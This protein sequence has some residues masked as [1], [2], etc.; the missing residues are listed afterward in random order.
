MLVARYPGTLLVKRSADGTLTVS[1]TLPFERYLDGIAE[2]PPSW[3]RAALEAQAIAARTYA[4]ATTGWTGKQ[5]E[6]LARP[7]CASTS[8]QV[9]GGMPVTPEP[10][11]SRWYRAVGA[12]SGQVLLYEGKPA[13]TF[14]FSTS[15]GQTYGNDQVFGGSPLPY[16]RSVV[17]SNDAASPESRWQVRI[18]FPDLARF[19]HAAGT[20][21]RAHAISNV[22]VHQGAVSVSGDGA[23][24]AIGLDAFIDAVNTWAP[25]LEPGRF[26]QASLP[27]TI[28]SKWL[29]LSPDPHAFVAAGRGWGHGVGM[30]QW[31]AYGKALLGYSAADILAYYYG[32][33]RPTTFPEPGLI[34]VIVAS[35]L[36]SL[37]IMPS[38]PGAELDGRKLGRGG[39][40]ISGG[41]QLT[42][43]TG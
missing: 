17:E 23:S 9:Y 41:T 21:P 15:D 39:V 26:P 40:S 13:Q 10:G 38:G 2:V 18:P 12:T 8:C 33:L 1:V 14:Y 28:P 30:V 24:R 43:T 29:R 19:L 22:R 20:W 5:G 3:P 34:H 35:G 27:E 4:L 11:I 6:T 31:G 7:I 36:A 37:R 32:G 25:C 42:V 16:L